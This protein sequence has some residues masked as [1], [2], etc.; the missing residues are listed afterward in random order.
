MLNTTVVRTLGIPS[1]HAAFAL[2]A[3]L[4]LCCV[5]FMHLTCMVQKVAA[6]LRNLL[7]CSLFCAAATTMAGSIRSSG[8][9]LSCAVK[10][11]MHQPYLASNWKAVA[12]AAWIMDQAMAVRAA[13]STLGLPVACVLQLMAVLLLHLLAQ[14][15]AG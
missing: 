4:P 10:T 5:C 3:A 1:S 6:L 12:K 11:H 9:R 15:V 13:L 7:R 14:C 8:T 2:I